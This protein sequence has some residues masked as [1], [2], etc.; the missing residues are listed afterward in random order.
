M[1]GSTRLSR[2]GRGRIP[3]LDAALA[4]LAAAAALADGQPRLLPPTCTAPQ[5]EC[6]ARDSFTSAFQL[7]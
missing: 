2:V 4:D 7:W 5:A 3:D 6:S 1:G